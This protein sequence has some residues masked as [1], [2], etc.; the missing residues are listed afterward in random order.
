MSFIA[1]AAALGTTPAPTAADKPAAPARAAT[2]TPTTG[3]LTA[4]AANGAPPTTAVPVDPSPK[5]E[6]RQAAADAAITAVA[7]ASQGMKREYAV[8]QN[9]VVL[10]GA[11]PLP[12]NPPTTAL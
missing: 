1:T 12:P 3:R 6:G 8:K 2:S 7:T 11:S 9:Q 10:S 5:R 4:N